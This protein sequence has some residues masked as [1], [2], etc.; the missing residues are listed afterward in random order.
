VLD[1][2][3][4]FVNALRSSSDESRKRIFDHIE[5]HHAQDF[6][7]GRAGIELYEKLLSALRDSG[8]PEVM[9][10]FERRFSSLLSLSP[11]AATQNLGPREEMIDQ[12]LDVTTVLHHRRLIKE[13][14]LLSPGPPHSNANLAPRKQIRWRPLPR[15]AVDQ[16]VAKARA[17]LEPISATIA[18]IRAVASEIATA[19]NDRPR[20]D[21][22]RPILYV[23]ATSSIAMLGVFVISASFVSSPDVLAQA[24]NDGSPAGAPQA[25][26]PPTP[27]SKLLQPNHDPK[28]GRSPPSPANVTPSGGSRQPVV[29][30]VPPQV[31]R[32]VSGVRN[33]SS[34]SVQAGRPRAVER[35]LGQRIT[36]PGGVLVLPEVTYYGVPVILDVPG[37]GFVDVPE[38]EYARLY[39]R[40]ASS[41]PE[42]IEAAM[43]SLRAIKAAEDL[44]IEAAQ[45]RPALSS[46]DTYLERDLSE[47]ISFDRP[48]SSS[49]RPGRSPGLY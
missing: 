15:F 41:D 7:N 44:E 39:E 31:D 46:D 1:H 23:A 42:Q 29:P 49:R 18:R 26:R 28:E 25:L 14:P 30:A 40:L 5:R 8:M 3:A 27:T 36:I 9:K 4:I 33:T 21:W 32:S 48:S 12:D 13:F 47:P 20:P 35:N 2:R 22:R 45:R 43:V 19:V 34:V 37:L 11:H 6:A 38:K 24:V 10:E 16:L 17:S